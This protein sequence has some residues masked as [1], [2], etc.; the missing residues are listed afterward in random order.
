VQ[1]EADVV[2]QAVGRVRPFTRP[3]EVITM[4]MGELPGVRYHLEFRNLSK[5]RAFF[6]V[7]TASEA[8]LMT[9]VEQVAR[10]R[11]MGHSQKA[12]AIKMNVSLS[13]VK[14]YIRQARGQGASFNLYKT[15]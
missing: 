13:S 8:A 6:D 14:R 11:A 9:K 7:P 12:I 3:R 4:H 15:P 1:K 2:V 10:L 5:A